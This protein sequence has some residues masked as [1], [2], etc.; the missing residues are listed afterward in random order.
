[1]VHDINNFYKNK[2]IKLEFTEELIKWGKYIED[3]YA[4]SI[5]Q[6]TIKKEVDTTFPLRDYQKEAINWI[7]KTDA[8]IL[9]DD[10]GL[11]KAQPLWSKPE[12]D[13]W[14]NIG[15]L[16]INEAIAD[17]NGGFGRI[18]AIYDRGIMDVY[19]LEFNDGSICYACL[20]HLSEHRAREKNC[21]NYSLLLGN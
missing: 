2:E 20:D 8:C 21:W 13:G 5:Q 12:L 16:S 7:S 19:K 4:Y 1:M 14:K 6:Q 18:T 17:P 15:D 3:K 10:P 11:G 9:G